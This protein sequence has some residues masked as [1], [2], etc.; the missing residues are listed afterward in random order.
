MYSRLLT[1]HNRPNFERSIEPEVNDLGQRA[2]VLGSRTEAAAGR[3]SGK[4][5]KKKS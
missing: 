1:I 4:V 5:K 3:G 2:R